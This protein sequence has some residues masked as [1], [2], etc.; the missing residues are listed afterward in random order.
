MSE[1]RVALPL[2]L[3]I[4]KF[5]AFRFLRSQHFNLLLKADKN[6]CTELLDITFVFKISFKMDRQTSFITKPAFFR[7]ANKR[8]MDHAQW[9]HW[10][11]AC[12]QRRILQTEHV[13]HRDS[14]CKARRI[15]CYRG[16]A[17]CLLWALEQSTK[18]SEDHA[19]QFLP[20]ILPNQSVHSLACAPRD[21]TAAAPC[22]PGSHRMSHK[23]HHAQKDAQ[24]GA[25]AEVGDGMLRGCGDS[26]IIWELLDS[27]ICQISID[28]L[29]KIY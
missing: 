20:S 29:S 6:L 22:L 2:S 12:S 14:V 10:G 19:S 11:G 1:I 4:M 5:D 21:R 23:D 9:G 25:G 26:M 27:Q 3:K 13:A 28:K 17:L 16:S 15:R 7:F 18:N 24:H 8:R